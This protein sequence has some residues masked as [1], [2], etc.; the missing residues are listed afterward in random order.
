MQFR[1]KQGSQVVAQTEGPEDRAYAEI[2]HYAALYRADGEVT[3]QVKHMLPSGPSWR[4]FA[5]LAK[6]PDSTIID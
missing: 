3:I 6:F 2:M 1:L 5:L 4:R